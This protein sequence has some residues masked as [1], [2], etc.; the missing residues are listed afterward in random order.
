MNKGELIEQLADK[1]GFTKRDATL[2]YDSFIETLTQALKKGEKVQLAGFGTF[3][4]KEVPQK[5]GINPFTKEKVVIPAC[6]K[7]VLKFGKS[8]KDE[9]NQ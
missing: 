6:K 2:A 8:Y 7:P 5:E 3:E 1:A 4:L 9:L